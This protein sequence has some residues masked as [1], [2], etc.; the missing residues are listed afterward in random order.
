MRSLRRRASAR[1]LASTAR[2]SSA[3]RSAITLPLPDRRPLQPSTSEENSQAL[4]VVSTF[5]GR[6][7]FCS[8]RMCIS[9]CGTFPAQSLMARM[10]GT[11]SIIFSSVS[12]G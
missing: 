2:N 9:C 12:R 8:V 6:G 1:S 3:C 10:L 5:T 4:W 11:C 7:R